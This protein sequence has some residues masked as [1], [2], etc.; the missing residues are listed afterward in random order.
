MRNRALLLLAVGLL[1]CRLPAFAQKAV[2]VVRHGEKI[3]GAD[4]RLSEAGRA[5]AERLGRMLRD[6]GVTAI[7]STDTD[8]TRDTVA[9][10][11]AALGVKVALYD[12]ADAA[13]AAR[14]HAE[15]PDGI[16]VVAA[17]SNTIPDLLKTLG[18]SADFKIEPDEY[19]NLF[20]VVPRPAGPA[21]LM[22]LRF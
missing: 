6:A 17:H 19:D 18:C 21:T 22:R 10:L 12:R 15:Q 8:R 5:R 13:F 9:P 4:E 7:Y 1:A 16:V 14:I 20:V 3:S 11:A 2:F